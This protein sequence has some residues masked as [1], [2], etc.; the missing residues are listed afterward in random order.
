[1][2][3][4]PSEFEVKSD[5][6]SFIPARPTK[7][8][9]VVEVSHNPYE[10][11][12]CAAP[13]CRKSL[14]SLQ[15][16]SDPECGLTF[17]NFKPVQRSCQIAK[18]L[19][20]MNLAKKVVVYAQLLKV[21][22]SRKLPHVTIDCASDTCSEGTVNVVNVAEVAGKKLLVSSLPTPVRFNKD[23]TVNSS[24][25]IAS[26]SASVE[27]SR[28]P[29]ERSRRSHD[30]DPAELLTASMRSATLSLANSTGQKRVFLAKKKKAIKTAKSYPVLLEVA[31]SC[32]MPK[33]A[34]L[35]QRA[36]SAVDNIGK[37][38]SVQVRKQRN[39][40]FS[41][42]EDGSP[43]QMDHMEVADGDVDVDD[44]EIDEA[45][46][47]NETLIY[48]ENFEIQDIERCASAAAVV[49]GSS[50]QGSE[51]MEL[52]DSPIKKEVDLGQSL[53]QSLNFE[54]INNKRSQFSSGGMVMHQSVGQLPPMNVMS[55]V[56]ESDGEQ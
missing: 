49:G 34:R 50:E 25:N 45:D 37:D 18:F 51:S 41:S 54:A 2:Q 19:S 8:P 13:A 12:E 1:M 36:V 52:G 23:L 53:A 24:V 42:D 27:V 10:L 5:K 44:V 4:Y 35:P 32:K 3:E 7:A 20:R 56:L 17:Q 48:D 47:M 16:A 43:S 31:A 21:I 9:E 39:P 28:E 40:F 38:T 46:M 29:S 11:R 6:G 15:R 22:R 33:K 55:P 14:E 26:V 30:S